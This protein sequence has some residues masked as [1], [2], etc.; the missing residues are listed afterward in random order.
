MGIIE[1]AVDF[2]SF[3]FVFERSKDSKIRIFEFS[4]QDNKDEML[5][6]ME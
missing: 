6:P 5:P 4:G 2:F 3:K 1:N